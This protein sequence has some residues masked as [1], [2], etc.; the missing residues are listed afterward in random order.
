MSQLLRDIPLAVQA[1]LMSAQSILISNDFFDGQKS[2]NRVILS[3]IL[4]SIFAVSSTLSQLWNVYGNNWLLWD[5]THL[6]M[7]LT[8]YLGD[9]LVYQARNY[10]IKLNILHGKVGALNQSLI[11]INRLT[12]E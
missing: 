1:I 4:L 5:W 12:S 6:I 2:E 8:M 3:Q 7:I 10:P 11:S 9:V